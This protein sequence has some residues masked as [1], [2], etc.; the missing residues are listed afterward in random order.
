MESMPRSMSRHSFSIALGSRLSRPPDTP[1]CPFIGVI[2]TSFP[3]TSDHQSPSQV[4]TEL[5]YRSHRLPHLIRL[6]KWSYRHSLFELDRIH[7][8][9]LPVA[10]ALRMLV[11][12]QWVARRKDCSFVGRRDCRHSGRS[13]LL[14]ARIGSLPAHRDWLGHTRLRLHCCSRRIAV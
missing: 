8:R 1:A 13:D 2:S 5:T 10:V 12:A 9:S 11:V 4:S 3:P 6:G 14:A 7:S